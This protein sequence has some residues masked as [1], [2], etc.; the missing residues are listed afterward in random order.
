M[1][2]S[3]KEPNTNI[4]TRTHT[5]T[6]HTAMPQRRKEEWQKEKRVW[7]ELSPQELKWVGVSF[8]TPISVHYITQSITGY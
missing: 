3:H 5:I 7:K 6:V 4:H 1:H 2:S 8:L